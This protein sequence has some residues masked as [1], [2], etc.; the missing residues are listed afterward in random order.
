MRV[1]DSPHSHQ[2]FI[3]IFFVYNC[4]DFEVVSH[5]FDL[6]FPNGQ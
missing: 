1:L 5:G 3:S 2:H 4:S 6:Y